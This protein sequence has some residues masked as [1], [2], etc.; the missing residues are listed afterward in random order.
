[1]TNAAVGRA[2]TQDFYVRMALACAA[3][4]F[5]GFAPTYWLPMATGTLKVSAILHLHGL[6]F[7][8]WTL[9]FVAQT[10]LAASG[11]LQRH[12][13]WGLAGISLATAMTIIGVLSALSS[14]KAA[15][16][17]GFAEAAATFSIVPLFGIVLFAVFFV[18]AVRAVQTPET[19]KRLMLLASISILEAPIARWFLTFLAPPGAVGPPP[20][21]ATLQPALVACLLILVAI[22][23]DVRNA[24]RP[25]PAYIVG[26]IAYLALKLVTIP[27]SQTTLWKGFATS[28]LALVP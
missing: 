10:W 26:G 7:F 2:T 1:M 17:A 4:A 3:V 12:R 18:L 23:R 21:S 19:H 22:V 25:H 6:I 9:F 20:V 15:G 28:L 27:F 24:G 11:R 14:M 5:L 13:A 16:A 8:T